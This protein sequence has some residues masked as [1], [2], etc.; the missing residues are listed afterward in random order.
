[1]TGKK[2]G[3]AGDGQN[4]IFYPNG[5]ASLSRITAFPATWYFL[6]IRSPEA[7]NFP[8]KGGLWGDLFFMSI[9]PLRFQY[10]RKETYLDH[11]EKTHFP[12]P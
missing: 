5:N 4:K 1:M 12:E 8:V 6:Q 3:A 7:A 11:A 2:D 10:D 9:V